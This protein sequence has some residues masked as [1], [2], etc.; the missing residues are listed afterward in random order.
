MIDSHVHLGNLRR[1]VHP[2]VPL[3]AQQWVDRMNRDGVE[4]SVLLP[5]ESPETCMGYFLTEDALRARDLYPER[6]IP[7]CVVDP[8]QPNYTKII[9]TFIEHYGCR[10]FGEHLNALPFDDPKNKEIYAICDEFGLP[11]VFDMGCTNALPD[12]RDLSGLESCLREFPRCIFIGH[13]PGWWAAISADWDGTPG[14]PTGPVVPGGAADRLL[15]EYD[16]MWADLSAGSGYNALTRD[17]EFTKGFIQRHWRKLLYGTDVVYHSQE[18]PITRWIKS[19]DA[20][21]EVREAIAGGNAR[22][23]LKLEGYQR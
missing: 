8:R 15:S 14:Y 21:P 7:F 13:G 22:R 17:P 18:L 3:T 11:L 10:G 5:L 23:L 2:M 4:M 6:L 19:L 9:R 1:D 20:P 16:N 12:D